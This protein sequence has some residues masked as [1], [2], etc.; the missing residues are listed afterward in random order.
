MDT[1]AAKEHEDH[2]STLQCAVEHSTSSL[3]FGKLLSYFHQTSVQNRN[4]C[5]L[6]CCNFNMSILCESELLGL[7]QSHLLNT[8]MEGCGSRQCWKMKLRSTVHL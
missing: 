6:V 7:E 4:C 3:C 8:D 2:K 5:E 1:E